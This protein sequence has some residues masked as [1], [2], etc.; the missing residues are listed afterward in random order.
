MQSLGQILLFVLDIAWIVALVQIVM[1]WL[2]NFQ[3]LNM[4]QPLVA[5]LWHGL[6]RLLEPAYRP[7]RRLLPATGGI[8]FAP[9]RG[10]ADPVGTRHCRAKQPLLKR[11][12]GRRIA[13]AQGAGAPAAR[14]AGS[15]ARARERPT[16]AGHLA[17]RA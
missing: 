16:A 4:R 2:I 1:S 15:R 11:V 10:P 6:T 3:I 14:R 8:D 7:I 5:Q 13:L 17:R 9:A 12:V